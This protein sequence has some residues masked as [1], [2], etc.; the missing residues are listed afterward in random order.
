VIKISFLPLLLLAQLSPFL[1]K[2]VA[3]FHVD[4]YLF[5]HLPVLT[6]VGLG[7]YLGSGWL[8]ESFG[9]SSSSS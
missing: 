9:S 7:G 6:S 1:K 4:I 2:F 3:I 8:E 5:F